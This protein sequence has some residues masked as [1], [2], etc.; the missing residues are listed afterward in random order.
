MHCYIDPVDLFYSLLTG[1]CHVLQHVDIL[2]HASILKFTIN[3][4]VHSNN[5]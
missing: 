3:E 4:E 2:S 5:A 1:P